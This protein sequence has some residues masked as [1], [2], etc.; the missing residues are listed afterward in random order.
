MWQP[1]R[2][3][4]QHDPSS[5]SVQLAVMAT[6]GLCVAVPVSLFWSAVL[7]PL[8]GWDVAAAVYL[9][10]AWLTLRPLDAVR[11][12][13]LA[14]REDPN[15]P[16]RDALLLS[17]CLASLLA[18]SVL[19]VTAH[20]LY[21]HAEQ[22]RIGLGVGSVLMSWA[23]VH[24]VFAAR[25]ARLYYTGVDGGI[26][27]HQGTCPPRYTDF[28]YV[29]FTVGMT[30]QVSDTNLTSNEMRSTVLRHSLLSYL[31]GAVLIA[32]TVNLLAGLAR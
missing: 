10:W 19:L 31:F 21:R 30:F 18:I 25:Y 14:V 1:L 26:D 17:A 15:R 4:R 6:A 8:I 20:S 9:G 27:F 22:L 13:R 3:L 16:L 7:G 23:V 24:T 2:A 5:S 29:A 12:A 28:A 32:A 11:T